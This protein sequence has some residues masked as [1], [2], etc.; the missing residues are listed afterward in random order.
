MRRATWSPSFSAV[1][2]GIRNHNPALDMKQHELLAGLTDR[3]TSLDHYITSLALQLRTLV[4][5]GGTGQR[6]S[7]YLG[8]YTHLYVSCV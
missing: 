2:V 7:W 3:A 4:N 1:L 6:E 8:D 5:Q